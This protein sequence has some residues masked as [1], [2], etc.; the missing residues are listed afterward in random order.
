M[1]FDY[2]SEPYRWAEAWAG[3]VVKNGGTVSA[4]RMT[5]M[6]ATY[7]ALI[8]DRTFW[9][10]DDIILLANENAGQA[11][12]SLKQRRLATLVAA[13]TFT[14]DRGYVLN[15]T[16]QY[17]NTNFIP[18]VHGGNGPGTNQRIGVY[19]RTNVTGS[20]VS[21]GTSDAAARVLFI[22]NRNAT[23][24][25]I[26][27]NALGVDITL[28]S[29]DSRGLKVGSRSAGGTVV[30]LFDRGVKA[31]D[32]TAITPG[33]AAPTRSIYIGALNNA[34]TA[35]N[36][37]ASSPALVVIGGVLSDAQELSFYNTVQAFMTAIG[38]QV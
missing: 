22:N 26:R 35:A 29:A 32:G 38:A 33:S 16:T 30:K 10:I 9:L 19:E 27:A 23:V 24:A 12:T 4:A 1:V 14:I 6:R 11:L 36:F 17:I 21:A 20:G 2:V 31:T 25:T 7:A 5:L 37:R 15:G 18:S 13:P 8:A 3:A 28:S 34:G